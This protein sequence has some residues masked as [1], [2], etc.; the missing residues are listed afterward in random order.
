MPAVAN[1]P[2]LTFRGT[3]WRYLLCVLT[4][5]V[6]FLSAVETDYYAGAV[7]VLV[8]VVLG[9]A[10]FV[11]VRWRRRR[12]LLVAVSLNL[13]SM[14]SSLAAGPALLALASVAT[15][16]R[17]GEI[18]A[19][20]VI[21]TIASVG[22]EL[23]YATDDMPWWFMLLVSVLFFALFIALGMYVGSR[24]EL[25]A[26]LLARAES[27]EAEQ[28]ARVAK[29]RADERTRIA[30]DMHDALAHRLSMVALH[31]GAL[32]YRSDLDVEAVRRSAEIIRSS[33]HDALAELRQ[34]LGMLREGDEEHEPDRPQPAAT[35]LS[36]LLDECR[37][38]GMRLEEE[39]DLDLPAVPASLGRTVYRVVQELLTNARKHAPG[40]RVTVRI[41]G[42]L[43]EGVSVRVSNP[44][45]VGGRA[46]AP[47][48]GYGLVGVAERVRIAGGRFRHEL[49]GDDRFVAQA[50]I[51]WSA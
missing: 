34:T 28:W 40:T 14:V 45:R 33:T 48:S 32:S 29:A 18:A 39:I 20:F 24:R 50:W 13:A 22:Y 31:S 35:D 44:L 36:A 37:A 2:P 51:P 30:R 25:M 11:V 1:P 16:R 15:R 3:L 17:W 26:S 27:A 49:T 5:V 23:I 43:G 41:A 12:P 47:P 46:D 21:G 4:S 7:A 6:V 38:G 8:D 19:L 9:I 10:S 42:A